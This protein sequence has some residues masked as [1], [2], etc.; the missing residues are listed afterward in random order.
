M[1]LN[2]YIPQDFI[3]AGIYES[4]LSSSLSN[5]WQPSI[6]FLI[7]L[8]IKQ[9]WLATLMSNFVPTFIS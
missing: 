1:E 5:K 7:H 9:L 8:L 6:I 4:H 2:C 3:E